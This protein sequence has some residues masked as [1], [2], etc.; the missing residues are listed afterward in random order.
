LKLSQT[1]DKQTDQQS[2]I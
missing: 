1:K 2:V